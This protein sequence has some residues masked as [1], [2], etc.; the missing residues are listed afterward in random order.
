M[1]S[2]GRTAVVTGG[3]RGIGRATC[4]ELAYREVN[5]IFSHAGNTVVAEATR[6]ELEILGVQI[7][8]V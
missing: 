6:K 4:L 5:V 1:S 7:R 8:T 2:I 3:S